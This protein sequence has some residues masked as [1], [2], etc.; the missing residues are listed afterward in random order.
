MTTVEHA[1]RRGSIRPANQADLLDIYRIERRVF[2]QPWPFS[3]FERYIGEPAF[4]VRERPQAT[5]GLD[6]TAI[7][8]Y[9]VA[10]A[11]PNHARPLGHIKD[12]AVHPAA[13]GDG[14]GGSLLE[15]ALQALSRQGVRSVKLEVRHTNEPARRLYRRFG[16][17]VLRTIPQYYADGE[18]AL[19]MVV[20]LDERPTP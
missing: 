5:T 1:S 14:V 15:R 6:D 4:L 11:I 12:I 10:D 20:N 19:I 2:E 16:F 7:L 8:G 3:A 18:D 13:Q 9:V 17:E